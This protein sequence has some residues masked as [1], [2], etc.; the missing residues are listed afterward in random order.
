MTT[1]TRPAGEDDAIAWSLAFASSDVV[2]RVTAL[3]FDGAVRFDVAARLGT[4]SVAR[5]TLPAMD[6]AARLRDERVTLEVR[7]EVFGKAIWQ[8]AQRAALPLRFTRALTTATTSR[9]VSY[10]GAN[11]PLGT[12]L[13]ALCDAAKATPRLDEEAGLVW[14]DAP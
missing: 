9:R 4:T 8:L 13:Q 6:L 3:R 12:V 14:I 2:L 5:V 10:E 1:L 11:R 7:D